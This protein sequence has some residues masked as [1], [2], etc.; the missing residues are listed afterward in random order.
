VEW[1]KKSR[2]TRY[3]FIYVHSCIQQTFLYVLRLMVTWEFLQVDPCWNIFIFVHSTAS[4]Y[5]NVCHILSI[6]MHIF[7]CFAL[8]AVLQI[9]QR[10]DWKA[11]RVCYKFWLWF[12]VVTDVHIL[13]SNVEIGHKYVSPCGYYLCKQNS[14][15]VYCFLKGGSLLSHILSEIS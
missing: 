7:M 14:R 1:E 4:L 3:M 2:S 8:A 9:Q 15:S 10:A 12:A 13:L 6:V 5:E 11:I